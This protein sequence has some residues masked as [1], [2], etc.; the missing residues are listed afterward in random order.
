MRS[1]ALN[2]AVYY[3]KNTLGNWTAVAIKGQRRIQVEDCGARRDA[4]RNLKRMADALG[5]TLHEKP[6]DRQK[7][8]TNGTN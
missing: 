6:E 5:W 7:E 4:R 8:N 1:Y 3:H 2:A